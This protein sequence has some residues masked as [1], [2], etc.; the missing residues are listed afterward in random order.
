MKKSRFSEEQIV[1]ILAEAETGKDTI[2]AVCRKHAISDDRCRRRAGSPGR[3]GTETKASLANLPA[4]GRAAP[5]SQPVT[6]PSSR[7]LPRL[8]DVNEWPPGR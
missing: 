2:Q 4:S 5:V 3:V 1:K 6:E 8:P 7:R